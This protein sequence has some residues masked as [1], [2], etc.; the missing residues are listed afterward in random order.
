MN[1]TTDTGN[2]RWYIWL[3]IL[4]TAITLI[5]FITGKNLPDF[6]SDPSKETL[7]GATQ[8]P[9]EPYQSDL[10]NITGCSST[11]ECPD[12]ISI[13]TLLGEGIQYD[14]NVEYKVAINPEEKIRFSTGWCT[15]EEELLYDNLNHMVY[16]FVV[17]GVSLIDQLKSQ[18]DESVDL[19]DPAVT[20]YCYFIGSS[21]DG[22]QSGQTYRII[23]GFK[24]DADIYDGWSTFQ[25]GDYL[26]TYIVTVK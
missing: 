18:Y 17:D 22:W 9:I 4:A 15:N 11:M 2:K 21:I 3:G 14:F 12:S 8:M 16:V 6:F 1:K 5:V 7:A 26:R 25:Q 20:N 23:L 24:A 19:D 13:K 10:I